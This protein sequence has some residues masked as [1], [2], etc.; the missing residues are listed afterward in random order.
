MRKALPCYYKILDQ[1]IF[2]LK[3]IKDR[4]IVSF[5]IGLKIVRII[6]ETWRSIN[7]LILQPFF[8]IRIHSMQDWTATMRHG[9]TRKRRKRSKGYRKTLLKEPKE[10]RFHL[11]H[12][13]KKGILQANNSRLPNLPQTAIFKMKKLVFWDSFLN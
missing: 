11:D 7:R 4:G 10:K 9:F 6:L 13:S 3:L 1:S 12:R 8:L 2:S 5:P